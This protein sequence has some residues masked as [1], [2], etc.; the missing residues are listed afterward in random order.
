MIKL[1]QSLTEIRMVN[2]L[3]QSISRIEEAQ[4]GFFYLKK[5]VPCVL[6]L[7]NKVN[8]KLIAMALLEGLRYKTN[9]GL[10]KEYLGNVQNIFNGGTEYK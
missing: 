6:Y 9:G 8:K 10:T 1:K 5:Y 7:E 2:P 4:D 3:R